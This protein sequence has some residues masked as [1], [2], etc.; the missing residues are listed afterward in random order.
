MSFEAILALILWRTAL[1]IIAVKTATTSYRDGASCESGQ[2]YTRQ[3][4]QFPHQNR[5]FK[6]DPKS[7]N[8]TLPK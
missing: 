2:V 3:P 6:L 5:D 7:R 8:Q 1:E 4:R